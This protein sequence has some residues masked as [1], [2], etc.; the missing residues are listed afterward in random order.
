MSLALEQS[1]QPITFLPNS[2]TPVIM[3][4]TFGEIPLPPKDDVLAKLEEFRSSYRTHQLSS[5]NVL[6]LAVL[7]ISKLDN[8][9]MVI[10][11]QFTRQADNPRYVLNVC[12]Q[13][14]INPDQA[15][16][17]IDSPSSLLDLEKDYLRKEGSFTYYDNYKKQ[18]RGLYTFEAVAR[19][20]K[21]LELSP[22][23]ISTSHDA[24]NF[25]LAIA[26]GLKEGSVKG[27]YTNG[28]R[29]KRSA[30]D[31]SSDNLKLKDKLKLA[32]LAGRNTSMLPSDVVARSKKL[33]P[34]IDGVAGYRRRRVRHF[35]AAQALDKATYQKAW[36]NYP[37]RADDQA[38][39]ILRD[40]KT[41]LKYHEE[42]RLTAQ[43]F[44]EDE[45]QSDYDVI[46]FGQALTN[47][48]DRPAV[49]VVLSQGAR[50]D[51]LNQ[52]NL[53]YIIDQWALSS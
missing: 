41:T 48:I 1:H 46:N 4:P 38:S 29:I 34:E 11:D 22:S 44:K 7:N 15:I 35:L 32:Y 30:D 33:L 45:R 42:A 21:G 8:L 51:Y 5:A 18:S 17:S 12:L 25:G 39:P 19:L 28:M 31:S 20:L 47:L 40:L 26:L 49:R 52:L 3:P 43:F 36:Q 50:Y 23:Y 13:A 24:S 2:H 37:L 27:F 9:K 16:V 14:A 53:S 10:T 6:G